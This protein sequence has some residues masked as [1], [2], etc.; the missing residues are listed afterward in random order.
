MLKTENKIF[1]NLY[2]EHGGKLKMQLKEMI[3]KTQKILFQKE[4]SG[5]LMR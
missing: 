1:K 2:N 3:G 4:E 5:L